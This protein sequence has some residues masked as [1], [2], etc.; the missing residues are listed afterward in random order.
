MSGWTPN[1]ERRPMV[2]RSAWL[3]LLSLS[4]LPIPCFSQP[5][6]ETS[7]PL[8]A[9]RFEIRRATSPIRVD[10]VLDEAAWQEDLTYDLPYEWSP[11]DN[12]PAPVQTDF[13]V[14]YDDQNLYA[15]W[16]ARDPDPSQIRAHLMDR[17]AIDTFVQDDHVV[18]MIDPFN[19]ERRGFQFRINPLGVQA[20]AVFS[21]NEG[22]E[23]FSFDM[24]WASAA[25]I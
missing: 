24:I 25:S 10:G 17:D 16:R 8:T 22:I 14:T 11:G 18:L 7:A 2:R 15:A 9:R 1:P 13:L 20:D 3:S 6:Q 4:F 21:E 5:A 19:D 23:D 12:V